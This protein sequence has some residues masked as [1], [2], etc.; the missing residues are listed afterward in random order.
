MRGRAGPQRCRPPGPHAAPGLFRTAGLDPVRGTGAGG[1]EPVRL[2]GGLRGAGGG[3]LDR[4]SAGV[5][6]DELLEL[7]YQQIPRPVVAVG[8]DHG[9]E[10]ALGTNRTNGT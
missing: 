8:R 10:A 2:S 6:G 5:C 9:L 1:E 4:A 7:E 3:D